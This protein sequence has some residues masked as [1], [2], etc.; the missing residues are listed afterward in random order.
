[1]NNETWS[2]IFSQYTLSQYPGGDCLTHRG[3][4]QI[5]KT[6]SGVRP[7]S[8]FLTEEITKPTGDNMEIFRGLIIY[9][10]SGTTLFHYTEP[11]SIYIYIYS[12]VPYNRGGLETLVCTNNRGVEYG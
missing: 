10:V 9:S 5:L 6:F 4:F 8:K 7:R 1:M 3:K 2:H 12:K 11:E